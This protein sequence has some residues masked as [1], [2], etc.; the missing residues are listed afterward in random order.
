MSPRNLQLKLKAEDISF[1]TLLDDLRKDIAKKYLRNKDISV[2]EVAY[3]IGFSE[4]SAF[5]RA[6]KRWTGIYA[7]EYRTFQ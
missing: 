2:A 5:Y 6:F 3:F 1:Q 7:K 4:A